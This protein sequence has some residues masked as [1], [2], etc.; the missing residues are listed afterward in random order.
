VRAKPG[1]LKVPGSHCAVRDTRHKDVWLGAFITAVLFT[2]EKVVIGLY[3][4]HTSTA[5]AYGAAGSLAIWLCYSAQIFLF[6]AEFTKVY[7]NRYGSRIVPTANAM[8]VTDKVRAE[9][10]IRPTESNEV[11]KM[12]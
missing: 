11:S 7:A 9:Q 4:G 5:S 6:R 12:R 3:L 1:R 8:L 2:V 10:V